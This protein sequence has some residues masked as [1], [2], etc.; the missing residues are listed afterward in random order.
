VILSQELM[1]IKPMYRSLI[2]TRW[3]TPSATNW[4]SPLGEE[5]VLLRFEFFVFCYVRRV[6]SFC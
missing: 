1:N 3:H 4:T 2:L 5:S 6:S